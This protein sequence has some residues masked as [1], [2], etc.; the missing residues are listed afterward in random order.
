MVVFIFS[1]YSLIWTEEMKINAKELQ[2]LTVTTKARS[3]TH[4]FYS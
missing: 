4:V 3:Y 2:I 1:F